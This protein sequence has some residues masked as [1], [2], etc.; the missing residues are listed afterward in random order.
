MDG[1]GDTLILHPRVEAPTVRA[2]LKTLCS[3]I[4]NICFRSKFW[5]IASEGEILLLRKAC[6]AHKG[7]L[8]RLRA[9]AQFL[10]YLF[11]SQFQSADLRLTLYHHL[12]REGHIDIRDQPLDNYRVPWNECQ[13]GDLHPAHSSSRTV[14][15]FLSSCLR[16]SD[17][18]GSRRL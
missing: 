9:P 2:V 14:A 7:L 18:F 3:Q 16:L 15:T 11:F 10:C 1:Q 5:F 8:G 6:S 17:I 13:I 12:A 4:H